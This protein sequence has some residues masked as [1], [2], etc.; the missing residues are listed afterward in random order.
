M[1]LNQFN[2]FK[3]IQKIQN[4]QLIGLDVFRPQGKSQKKKKIQLG[5]D[6]NLTLANSLNLLWENLEI[7]NFFFSTRSRWKFDPSIFT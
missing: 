6:G 1:F 2:S 5:L 3:E 4:F 7:Q